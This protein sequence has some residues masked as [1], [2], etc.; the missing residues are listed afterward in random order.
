ML[1]S[2]VLVLTKAS[3]FL[4]LQV[5]WPQNSKFDHLNAKRNFCAILYLHCFTNIE[6]AMEKKYNKSSAKEC[7][8][9]LLRVVITS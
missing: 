7:T 2:D 6:S 5:Y 3:D 9:K 4:L 1:S 8:I